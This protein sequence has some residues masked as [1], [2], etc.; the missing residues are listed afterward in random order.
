MSSS[1]SIT[2]LYFAGA[3]T[4]TGLTAET[5]PI[6][7]D[8]GLPLSALP[9]LLI[10]RHSNA[11]DLKKVLDSSQWSVDAEMVDEPEKVILKGGEEVA[12]IPPVSG[13]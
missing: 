4:S 10:S 2:I 9:D 6:P 12:V 1:A 11:K 8:P 5:I 3:S 13:G 7:N